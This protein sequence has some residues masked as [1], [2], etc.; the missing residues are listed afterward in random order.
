MK[1]YL[2]GVAGKRLGDVIRDLCKKIDREPKP[3]P[4]IGRIAEYFNDVAYCYGW[5]HVEFMRKGDTLHLFYTRHGKPGLTC[6]M[7]SMSSLGDCS[8]DKLR[9]LERQICRLEDEEEARA[10][11]ATK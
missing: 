1:L 3:C 2:G 5:K 9:K 8:N 6:V 10:G 11:S 7:C 4:L